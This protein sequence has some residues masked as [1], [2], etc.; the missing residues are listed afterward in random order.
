MFEIKNDIMDLKHH[1]ENIEQNGN[2]GVNTEDFVISK[3][4]I[5]DLTF[6]D[7]V[8]ELL[9]YYWNKYHGNINRIAHKLKLSN[10]T[11]YRKFKQY[12]LKN[13]KY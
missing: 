4:K 13:E 1:I 9:T 11:L 3:E 2:I 8:Q 7:L 6:D 12:G 10:R 5:D